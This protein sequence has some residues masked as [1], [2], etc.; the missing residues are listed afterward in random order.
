VPNYVIENVL[1]NFSIF[2]GRMLQILWFIFDFLLENYTQGVD[3][4][5]KSQNINLVENLL[6]KYKNTIDLI[7]PQFLDAFIKSARNFIRIINEKQEVN[8]F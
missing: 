1:V 8:M 5:F 2:T 6:Q 3:E 7:A 4:L